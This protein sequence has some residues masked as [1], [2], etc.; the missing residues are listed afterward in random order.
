MVQDKPPE[1][2]TLQPA[3]QPNP[4]RQTNT[5]SGQVQQV[6]PM[7]SGQATMP[8]QQ[9]LVV[10]SGKPSPSLLL[11]G[12]LTMIGSIAV[13]FFGFFDSIGNIDEE[14]FCCLLCNGNA[15]GL[16]MMS[17]YSFR[18]GIWESNSGK[19]GSAAMSYVVGAIALLFGG[20]LSTLFF[21][22]I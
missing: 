20:F 16:G 21:I 15:I 11:G 7:I 1:A 14:M 22:N 18:Y 8:G 9:P 17:V 19:Q 12:F 4:I 10:S 13:S 2:I 6:A 3:N 5:F